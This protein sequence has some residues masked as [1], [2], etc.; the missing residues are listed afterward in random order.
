MNCIV[1]VK[2]LKSSLPTASFGSW[3][4]MSIEVKWTVQDHQVHVSKLSLCKSFKE[5]SNSDRN[6]PPPC[7]HSWRILCAN[8]EVTWEFSV[9]W[10]WQKMVV[11]LLWGRLFHFILEMENQPIIFWQ[12]HF[13]LPSWSLQPKGKQAANQKSK[14]NNTWQSGSMT[15]PTNSEIMYHKESAVSVISHVS[16][17]R[18]GMCILCKQLLIRQYVKTFLRLYAS[19]HLVI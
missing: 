5:L 10:S 11:E 9:T 3:G 18:E 12:W 7:D 8:R 17:G 19:M 6:N 2:P 13:I 15:V 16:S 14:E 1:P 4:N